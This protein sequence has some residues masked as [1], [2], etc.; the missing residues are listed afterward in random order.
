MTNQS[1]M[2]AVDPGRQSG[3]AYGSRGD[4]ECS[5]VVRGDDLHEIDAIIEES[6]PGLLVIEDQFLSKGKSFTSLKTLLK[7]RYTWET[8]SGLHRVP[9]RAIYPSEWQSHYRFARG[10]GE[11]PKGFKDRMISFA[12]CLT[13]RVV[14]PDEADAILLYFYYDSLS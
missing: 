6:N 14:L 11:S 1:R 13:D 10:R 4:L 9:V 3:Y 5:G 7:Y 2:L 8:L 12:K